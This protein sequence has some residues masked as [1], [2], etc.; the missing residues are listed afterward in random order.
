[1]ADNVIWVLCIFLCLKLHAAHG[2]THTYTHMHTHSHRAEII[3]D[4]I[5][6]SWSVYQAEHSHSLWLTQ[7]SNPAL[8]K[9]PRP[10]LQVALLSPCLV[11]GLQHLQWLFWFGEPIGRCFVPF[12]L[13]LWHLCC[14]AGE[15]AHIGP[16]PPTPGPAKTYPLPWVGVEG[17]RG[18]REGIQSSDGSII[19]N[20]SGLRS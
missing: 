11:S 2:Y 5:N 7:R 12:S 15:T 6:S 3:V 14:P 17:G 13:V 16:G 4:A 10:A 8:A 1:M 18:E 20:R 9:P 19:R